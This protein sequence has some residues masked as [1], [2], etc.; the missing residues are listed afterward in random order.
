MLLCIG[1]L[2]FVVLFIYVVCFA[3]LDGAQ[4]PVHGVVHGESQPKLPGKIV[5]VLLEDLFMCLFSV[6]SMCLVVVLVCWLE[7]IACYALLYSY[8]TALERP[9]RPPGGGTPPPR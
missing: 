9:G 8:C 4:A 3:G 5:L 2:C 1:L 6:V 7:C